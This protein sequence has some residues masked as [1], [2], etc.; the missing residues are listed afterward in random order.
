VLI[1]KQQ[2]AH[3]QRAGTFLRR[4]LQPIT[5]GRQ[6]FSYVRVSLLGVTATVTDDG[7]V[8]HVAEIATRTCSPLP[9][10]PRISVSAIAND[11]RRAHEVNFETGRM[12]GR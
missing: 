5:V 9:P 1:L 8:R 3:E 4:C 2:A 6:L 11:R 7:Q 10:P 12:F